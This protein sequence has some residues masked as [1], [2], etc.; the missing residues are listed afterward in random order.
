ML[1][2][3]WTVL[4][5]LLIVR[6]AM[7]FQFQAVAAVAPRLSTQ[8]TLNHADIGTLVGLYLLPGL[9]IAIPGGFLGSRFS[10]L[11]MVALGIALMAL[12]G[13]IAGM[14]DSYATIAAGRLVSGVGAVIQSI[15]VVKM[16]ADWF[17]GREMITAMAVMLSGFPVGIA[18]ALP[19]LGILA[20]AAG[21][22]MAMTA[23]GGF[24]LLALAVLLICY[25]TPP[26]SAAT[27]GASADFWLPRRELLLVII[28]A[29][30]WTFY[31][32]AYFT[33]LAFGPALLIE[34]GMSLLD[35]GL[36]ISVSSWVTMA[37]VPLGGMLAERSGRPTAALVMG[38]LFAGTFMAALPL[39]DYPYAI[40]AGIGAFAAAPAG[41]IMAA[42][43]GVLSPQY[44]AQGNGIIYTFFYGGM[45]VC[46]ILAGW[47]ADATGTAATPIFMCAGVLFSMAAFYPLFRMATRR[48][49]HT[50]A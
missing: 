23:T 16:I 4:A 33:Y 1:A 12:G 17:D 45:G 47:L 40:N 32:I 22:Q 50:P 3:R 11:K 26:Q 48:L 38:C 14:A 43:I 34:R 19:V 31:N 29:L 5:L 13:F 44:R 6:F 18:V 30:L 37:A 25:R 28:G 2:N 35:A 27:T 8:L 36:A 46:P 41:I 7:G 42:A 9:I 20:D 21:W 49:A 10:D 15:F 39:F 24:C